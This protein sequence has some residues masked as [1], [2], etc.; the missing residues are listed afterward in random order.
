MGSRYIKAKKLTLSQQV[1][2]LRSI[3]PDSQCKQNRNQLE[4]I[5]KLVPTP[6]S[7]AYIVNVLYKQGFNPRTYV[8]EPQLA[9]LP[10]KKL[11]HVY[12]QAEQRLCLY[13]PSSRSQWNETMSI[14]KTIVPWASEWLLFYELWLAT[15]EW[16]G[17]GIH[18]ETEKE[19]P[20]VLT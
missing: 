11:P 13:Y 6:L 14:A 18:L 16:L 12:S 9:V 20:A 10:K 3:Y 2:G 5:G 19:D 15:G 8:R 17:G 1:Y 4:W 7:G